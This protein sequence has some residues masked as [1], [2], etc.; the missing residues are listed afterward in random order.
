[1]AAN[2]RDKTGIGWDVVDRQSAVP[3]RRTS[4][5]LPTLFRC[6]LD[7]AQLAA[8]LL[9]HAH[10]LSPDVHLAAQQLRTAHLQVSIVGNVHVWEP[11]PYVTGDILGLLHQL[12]QHACETH[13]R[14]KL[15]ARHN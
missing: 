13:I 14:G 12:N 5:Q 6:L 7:I 8:T 11:A 2:H 3:A 9:R 15:S 10:R 1:M 4:N